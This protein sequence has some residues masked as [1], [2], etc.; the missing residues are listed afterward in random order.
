MSSM[1]V[2][3]L[4]GVID[5]L[6][7]AIKPLEIG[8]QPGTLTLLHATVSSQLLAC[9]SREENAKKLRRAFQDALGE[10]GWSGRCRFALA[11]FIFAVAI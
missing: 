11:A 2:A 8:F 10:L 4:S 1:G 6:Y 3:V 5:S 7:C 9:V